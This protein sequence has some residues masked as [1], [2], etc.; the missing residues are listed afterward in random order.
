MQRI[1]I[2]CVIA[3]AVTFAVISCSS[4][5]D[6]K[7][8]K[9]V[10]EASSLEEALGI[11]AAY[12]IRGQENQVGQGEPLRAVVLVPWLNCFE[13]VLRKFPEARENES[14]V[15]FFRALQARHDGT[16]S[17][18]A[19][20]V[21]RA[22]MNY[23][24]LRSIEHIKVPTLSYSDDELRV[25]GMQLPGYAI[26]LAESGR[27]ARKRPTTSRRLEQSVT[28]EQ[29]LEMAKDQVPLRPRAVPLDES[30][31]DYCRKY[32]SYRAL[33]GNV[34]ELSDYQRVLEANTY[35]DASNSNERTMRERVEKRLATMKKDA[36]ESKTALDK[37]LAV[38]Q[39]RTTWFRSGHCTE[40]A[41]M[42]K[43]GAGP[44]K[45]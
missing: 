37:E 13:S 42:L 25:I 36:A 23:A 19:A 27:S 1:I 11:C 16:P 32:L 34:E 6:F 40:S 7:P 24:V 44:V 39:S 31:R 9:P 20:V 4:V 35:K 3:F 18:N 22:D 8:S 45:D 15:I 5:P 17:P 2:R 38:I 33:L 14:F 26:Y 12:Q 30:Q 41:G 10:A 29:S 21:D 43:K 28:S